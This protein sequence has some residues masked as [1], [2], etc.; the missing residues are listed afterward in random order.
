MECGKKGERMC[1]RGVERHSG[2][3]M[4]ASTC[5]RRALMFAMLL[6][7]LMLREGLPLVSLLVAFRRCK[8]LE[9]EVVWVVAVRSSVLRLG[10]DGQGDGMGSVGL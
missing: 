3:T 10:G 2:Q 4:T 6:A 1:V 7:R 9:E 5:W 8:R